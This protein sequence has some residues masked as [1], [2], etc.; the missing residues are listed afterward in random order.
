MKTSKIQLLPR[1]L[2]MALLLL[3]CAITSFA[4]KAEEM[5]KSYYYRRALELLVADGPNLDGVAEYFNKE[6]EEHPKNGYAYLGLTYIYDTKNRKGLA[7]EYANKAIK[8]LKKDKEGISFAYCLRAKIFLGLGEDKKAEKDWVASLK[9]NKDDSNTLSARADYNYDKGNYDLSNADFDKIIATDPGE[10]IGYMGKAR[11]CIAQN[12]YTE[13]ISLLDHCIKLNP[14]LTLA[15]TFKAEALMGQKRYSEASDNIIKALGM[16]DSDGG[17]VLLQEFKL[18]EADTILTKLRMQGTKEPNDGRWCYYEG[19]V[20]RNVNEYAKA[21]KAFLKANETPMGPTPLMLVSDCY[22][23]M[24]EYDLALKYIDMV[25]QMDT[26]D[27]KLLTTKAD[28]LY[29]DGKA[30]EAIAIYSK[31]IEE[32]PDCAEAYYRR[33]FMKDN[34]RNADG[35]I[36]DYSMSILLDPTHAYAYL[37]RADMHVLKG[38]EAAAKADY[39]K[40][41]QLDTTYGENNVAMFAYLALG[42][43]DKAIAFEDSVL[44]HS[45]SKGNLYDAACLYSRMGNAEK[46]LGYLRQSLEKGFMRFSHI[47]MDDDLDQLK[48]RDEFKALIKEYEEKVRKAQDD[49][50]MSENRSDATSKVSVIPFTRLNGVYQVKYDINGLLLSFIFDT[51]ASAVSISNVEAPCSSRTGTLSNQT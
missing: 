16:G 31:I 44:S 35:A 8:L 1:V 15:Y 51:G 46:A 33:G 38:N 11:N 10:A 13:A 34:L 42:E 21:A 27:K 50:D 20:L 43:K 36:K 48:E 9:V 37:G 17:L 29:D 5:R 12:K 7:L 30:G 26:T 22:S 45:S 32:N 40:A 2:L 23:S 19:M 24:G 39:Q 28:I 47:M 6:V 3:S 4:Q 18:P 25:I 41:I 14:D 49:E